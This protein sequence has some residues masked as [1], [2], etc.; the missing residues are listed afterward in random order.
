MGRTNGGKL[1]QRLVHVDSGGS[2]HPAIVYTARPD[3]IVRLL[4]ALRDWNPRY[5]AEVEPVEAEDDG[6]VPP[7]PL[8]CLRAWEN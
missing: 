6:N 2:K 1:P 4:R 3:V 5:Q 7:L 8:W